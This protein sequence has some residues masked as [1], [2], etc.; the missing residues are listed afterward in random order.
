M[1]PAHGSHALRDTAFQGLVDIARNIEESEREA[2]ACIRRHQAFAL[3][4]VLEIYKDT[5]ADTA[6]RLMI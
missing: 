5:F 1:N 2:S 6:T 3:A 4:P